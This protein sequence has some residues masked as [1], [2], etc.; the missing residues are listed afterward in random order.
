V[1]PIAS[2]DAVAKRKNDCPCW[3]LNPGHPAHRLVILLTG[4]SWL[5]IKIMKMGYEWFLAL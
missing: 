4:L 5:I 3:E 1:C 2:L